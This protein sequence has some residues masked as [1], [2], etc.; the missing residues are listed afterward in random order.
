[1]NGTWLWSQIIKNKYLKNL[2]VDVWLRQ[3]SFK[4]HGTSH[5]WNGFIRAMSWITRCLGW[6]IGNGK[7]IKIGLDPLAGV[8]SDYTLLEGLRLYLEDYG[9]CTLSD[10]L[11]R[12]VATSS[13]DYWISADDLELAGLWKDS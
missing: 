7:H 13:S 6:K 4:V 9:I 10:A 2:P 12:G 3:Q 1:M 11:N 8:S 5:M